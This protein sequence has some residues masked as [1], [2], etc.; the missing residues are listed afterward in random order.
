M[1]KAKNP[2][3]KKRKI[4]KGKKSQGKSRIQ[5]KAQAKK[6]PADSHRSDFRLL[7]LW[8]SRKKSLIIIFLLT[9]IIRF[10]Y[11]AELSSK[12]PYFDNPVVDAEAYFSAAKYIAKTGD[13]LGKGRAY[14]YR[15][16]EKILIPEL[17]LWVEGPYWQA[18]LY[19]YFLAFIIKLFGVSFWLI[20]IV[21]A[22]LS[23]VSCALVYSIS[24]YFFSHRIAFF[25]G[26]IFSLYG[27]LI[28]FSGEL[29]VP[30]FFIFLILWMF[31]YL[32]VAFETFQFRHWILFGL[33]FSMA[34]VAHSTIVVFLPVVLFWIIYRKYR[35]RDSRP[36]KSAIITVI[37]AC[38]IFPF[39]TWIR[40]M[41]ISGE[42]VI[43]STNS[44][45]NF[46]IGN[47]DDWLETYKVRP[48]HPWNVLVREPVR[49]KNSFSLT[50]SEQNS[51]FMKKTIS[52][53]M[54]HPGKFFV[55]LLEKIHYH[56]HGYELI[57]NVDIYHLSG[58]S[59]LLSV[60][61]WHIPFFHFPFG[62]LSPL[63]LVSF[64]FLSRENWRKYF[65]L[66]SFP[67]VMS[68]IIVLFFPTARYRVQIVPFFIMVA[69]FCV[70]QVIRVIKEKRSGK[71]FLI[72]GVFI[73]LLV[74]LNLPRISRIFEDPVFRAQNYYMEGDLYYKQKKYEKAIELFKK[75][76]SANPRHEDALTTLGLC[77]A[78]TGRSE[79][80]GKYF[81]RTFQINPD[82]PGNIFNLG[83]YYRNTNQWE[84][85]LATFEEYLQ[86]EES[87]KID[88]FLYQRG[89]KEYER[90][91]NRLRR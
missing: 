54:K 46:F 71:I 26:L 32:L 1:S 53:I 22:L 17:S 68:G 27:P 89:L 63:F 37:M 20:L 14:K 51:Y 42:N 75:T 61:L 45:I 21:Q 24:T 67:I 23:A 16:D 2:G 33:F 6:S 55:G 12:S 40:N 5:E 19:F 70:E 74:V 56:F 76:I 4:K 52:W 66:L 81:L 79:E 28:F 15:I 41:A 69:V 36:I 43:V 78:L 31:Y 25:S 86:K 30:F 7:S 82:F 87:Q 58:Y 9:F 57:R 64:F 10:I 29:L 34:L 88:Y 38:L 39:L 59:I 62:L 8:K 47:N 35:M 73:T 50:Q 84:K 80:A 3:K 85:A 60:L 13:W 65:L 11:V 18:P 48:G 91:R 77:Y 44:G 49:V 90:C 72:S 83:I